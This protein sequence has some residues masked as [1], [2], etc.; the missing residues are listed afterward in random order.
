M[1]PYGDSFEHLREEIQR[2]D[3]LLRR[4]VVVARHPVQPAGNEEFRGLV[5]SEGEVDDILESADFMGD[6]W[7][8]ETASQNALRPID[9]KLAE[10]RAAID[11]RRAAAPEG[12][13]RLTLPYLAQQFGLSQA[14]VDL[15]LVAL[16]PELDP[17]YE[18]LYAYLQDDVT[19]KRPSVD[20]SLNLLCRTEREKLFARRL[21]GPG[22]PLLHYQLLRLEDE[23]QDRQALFSRKFLKLSIPLLRFLLDE[24]P[25]TAESGHLSTPQADS[26]SAELSA[27][28]QAMLHGAIESILRGA[29]RQNIVRLCGHEPVSLDAAAQILAA[30]FNYSVLS[31]DLAPADAEPGRLLAAIRDAT[32]FDA[33]L[34]ISAPP[35]VPGESGARQARL[36][37][38]MWAEIA[39]VQGPVALLGPP[40]A[41]AEIPA[42]SAELRVWPI[43]VSGPEFAARHDAWEQSLAAA[44]AA[45]DSGA[46]ADGFHF[47][48]ARIRQAVNLA[49]TTAALRDPSNPQPVQADFAA[50][51]RA[52]STPSL[53]R[54]AVP[55]VPR[56]TW[57]DIV[58]PADKMAQLRAIGSRVRHR[59]QVLDEW[60]F[61]QKLSRGK[62]NI[63]LF[64]GP[65]GTGKTMAAEAMANEL[66]LN[67]FQIDL[68]TVVS[69]YIGETEGNLSAIFRE[70][71]N[72]AT[73]L[74]FD[75]AD[76]LFSKRTEVKDAHDRYANQEVNYLLQRVEQYEGLVI[77]A[78]NLQKNM[79]DAFLRRLQFVVDFPM[80]AEAQRESIWRNHF[81]PAAPRD[82]SINLPFL[83]RQFKLSGG[84]IRN[85]V[86][87][88]AFAAAEEGSPIGMRHL[89]AALRMETLKEGKLLMKAELG[90]Y[91]D[92]NDAPA[93][94][95]KS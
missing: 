54:F 67:L 45:A 64:T 44:G 7:R 82:A 38:Q 1:E 87:S 88:A 12:G 36:E 83:A 69:K 40:T 25:D 86:F 65:P 14:E 84:S 6:R 81:P 76:A 91:S 20:L 79:D 74:F 90:P 37:R 94:E 89:T 71:E 57:A 39:R 43:N 24:A 51:G 48:G 85:I 56:Y 28:S 59:R 72:T 4:A 73:L 63:A 35:P 61:G 52:L 23:P 80:P 17:R 49:F 16:A 21:L 77:L 68:S 32:L 34:A 53:T 66:G 92:L 70:A 13:P 3:L 58:L 5:I 11:A 55:I 10:V 78:T 42:E 47:G 60:G 50:A 9:D 31:V 19:R 8:R 62:G 22:A 30:A 27:G 2:L 41:F 26:A 75:E 18:T 15:L 95:V 33:M 29:S 93:R 46:L